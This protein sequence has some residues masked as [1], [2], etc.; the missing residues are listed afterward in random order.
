MEA[1]APARSQRRSPEQ[2]VPEQE[3]GGTDA[4]D[5]TEEGSGGKQKEAGSL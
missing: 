3:H 2:H 1:P 4:T 5:T